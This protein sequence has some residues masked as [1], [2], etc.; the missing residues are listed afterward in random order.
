MSNWVEGCLIEVR[1]EKVLI[2]AEWKRVVGKA[3]WCGCERWQLRK[4][5][6]SFSGA[7]IE[8]GF[9]SETKA[10]EFGKTWVKFVGM[11]IAI[12]RY[13][14]IW[15]ASIPVKCSSCNKEPR[16]KMPK[17]KWIH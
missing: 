3:L 10:I 17:A 12:R 7:V 5:R 13:K 2:A 1:G 11:A 9:L 6:N 4:S 8:A 15:A 16:E 14:G